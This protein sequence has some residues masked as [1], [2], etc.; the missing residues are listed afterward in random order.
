MFI[1]STFKD[2]VNAFLKSGA[3]WIALGITVLI[4][5]TITVLLI[6]NRKKKK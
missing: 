2:D 3:F 1:Q 4:V 6:K 5:I